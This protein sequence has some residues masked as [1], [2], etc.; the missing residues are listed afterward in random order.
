MKAINI[1]QVRPQSQKDYWG[2]RWMREVTCSRF[3]DYS[4]NID[5]YYGDSYRNDSILRA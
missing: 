2:D 3:R 5:F 1:A 4:L